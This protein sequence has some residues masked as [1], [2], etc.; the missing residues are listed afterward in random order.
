MLPQP[1]TKRQNSERYGW[2]EL[3]QYELAHMHMYIYMGETYEQV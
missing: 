3:E 2:I 1:V